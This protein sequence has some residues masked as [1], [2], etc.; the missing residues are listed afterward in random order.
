VITGY[1]EEEE[2]DASENSIAFGRYQKSVLAGETFNF[3]AMSSNTPGGSYEGAANAYPKVGPIVINEI[4]YYPTDAGN[5]AEYIELLNISDDPETLYDY[6]TS[7]PWKITDGIEYT[8]PSG[9][10]LTIPSG[11]YYLLIKDLAAFTS[12]YGAPVCGYAEWTSGKLNNGGE[13]VEIS[14]PGDLDGSERK[15]IRVD[16][17][18]Y[19]DGSH[20]DPDPDPWPTGADG[21]GDSLQRKF[22]NNY[23]N[24]VINWQAASETPGT[25]NPSP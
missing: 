22:G 13:K 6:T 19:S 8:F 15:Y 4:M 11:G 1:S 25:V 17:V 10:P 9:S 24:D 21:L 20:P 18:K 5:D 23:G 12:E 2:F 7:E 14:M 16:R 3:V